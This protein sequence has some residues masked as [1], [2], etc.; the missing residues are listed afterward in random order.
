M[1]R[2]SL[3]QLQGG[4]NFMAIIAAALIDKENILFAPQ[5]SMVI[6]FVAAAIGVVGIG[7]VGDLIRAG[8]ALKGCSI[9]CTGAALMLAFLP[10]SQFPLFENVAVFVLGT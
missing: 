2:L 1:V 8:R 4:Y 7:L 10:H 5:Q 6:A 9:V 3:V